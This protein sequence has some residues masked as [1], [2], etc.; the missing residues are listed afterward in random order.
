MANWANEAGKEAYL[1]DFS[2]LPPDGLVLHLG[3]RSERECVKRPS[4]HQH[5]RILFTWR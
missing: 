4:D 5:S 3:R 1:A 2:A